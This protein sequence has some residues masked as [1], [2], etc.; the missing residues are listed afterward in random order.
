MSDP[1]TPVRVLL[2]DDQALIRTGFAALV[3]SAPD[4]EVVAQAE[5]GVQA[6]ALVREHRPDVV[7]MDVRMPRLDGLGAT[8][9]ISADPELAG[10]HV[11]VLTTFE[12]DAHVAEAVRAGAAGF[13]G[14]D[15]EP[16]D[17]L[18]AIRTV[19]AGEALLSPS[20]T[21]SLIRRYLAAPDTEAYVPRGVRESELTPRELEVVS[22]VALGLDNAEIAERLVVSPLTAK[23]HVTRAMGKLGA[24]DRAQVVVWAYRSGLVPPTEG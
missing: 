6:L 18:D 11:L 13:L 12:T 4:L 7:V 1:S 19:A 3:A 17:F 21:R 10:V 15:V 24:R 8:R 16:A 5:D 23:T 20:A 22:L 2:A 14:K 9:E